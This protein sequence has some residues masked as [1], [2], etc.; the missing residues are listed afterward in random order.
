MAFTGVTNAHGSYPHQRHAG[1]QFAVLQ[2]QQ[3][4]TRPKGRFKPTSP[5]KS[6]LD[7]RAIWGQHLLVSYD[8]A[9]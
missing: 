5:K 7:G 2:T 9:S 1:A 8:A 6:R 4:A 3:E